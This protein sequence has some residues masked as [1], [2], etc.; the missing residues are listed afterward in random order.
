MTKRLLPLLTLALAACAGESEV[1]RLQPQGYLR[2]AP[3]LV[4]QADW[5]APETLTV[6]LVN[7]AFVPSDLIV[8]RNRPTR[9]VLRNSSGSDHTFVSEALFRTLAVH[10]LATPQAAM[11]GPWVEKVVVPAGQTVELD[12][13]PARYG[14]YRYEC[15]VTGHAL[16]GM[17]GVVNVVE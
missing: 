14:A 2:E 1:S 7:H 6:Q 9:L 10:R 17:T 3:E 13:I 4:A 5:S 16:L 8:H 15:T 12:F 11:E